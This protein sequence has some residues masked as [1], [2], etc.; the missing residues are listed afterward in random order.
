MSFFHSHVLH[1]PCKAQQ[2]ITSSVIS[3]AC[4]FLPLLPSKLF[5]A[6]FRCHHYAHTEHRERERRLLLRHPAI[7]P[8]LQL[9]HTRLAAAKQTPQQAVY[10]QF[11]CAPYTTDIHSAAAES[12]PLNPV[13][14]AHRVLLFYVLPPLCHSRGDKSRHTFECS[15][16][17]Q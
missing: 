7:H 11:Y 14:G 12:S 6:I 10:K 13:H 16:K 17:S 9:S 2:Q 1:P 8:S 4:L 15:V 5:R 3:E